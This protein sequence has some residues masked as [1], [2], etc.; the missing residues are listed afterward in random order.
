[1]SCCLSR[2]RDSGVG[3]EEVRV[4][5]KGIMLHKSRHSYV[6]IGLILIAF[7]CTAWHVHFI[8]GFQRPTA[9]H[10]FPWQHIDLL[11]IWMCGRMIFH[12]RNPYS[13]H[14]TAAIQ[15]KYY[16]LKSIP[17]N[18]RGMDRLGF[19]MG[20]A[21]PAPVALVFAWIMMLPWK[22]ARLAY[23]GLAV[24]LTIASVPVWLS[25]V[26]AKLNVKKVALYTAAVFASWPVLWGL[27]VENIALLVAVLAAVGCL[28]LQR[29]YQATAGVI[30][31][32]SWVKPQ[33]TVPLL[34]WLL[35]YSAVQRKWRF[36][37][38]F[39]GTLAVLLVATQYF[40]PKWFGLWLN[41]LHVYA[42]YNHLH[43][44]LNLVLPLYIEVPWALGV[45]Y[46]LWR[47]GHCGANSKVFGIAVGL[48]LA[49]SVALAP[50]GW[51][52]SDNYIVL[53]PACFALI[54]M[55]MADRVI[56]LLRRVVFVF[57]FFEYLLPVVSAA[58]EWSL[59]RNFFALPGVNVL[60]PFALSAALSI[61]LWKHLRGEVNLEED[62]PPEVVM[63][64]LPV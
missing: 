21:Y 1:M 16:G 41:V 62:R 54:E 25:V 35:F 34:L 40:L 61:A 39:G 10:S 13:S 46:I 58:L 15:L 24:L 60:L 3:G 52:F 31:A 55:R 6:L 11:P 42:R 27:R 19:A 47:A 14:A 29:G 43:L 33:L 64:E 32:L 63:A 56:V 7:L 26:K 51:P 38:A 53:L 18:A 57:L 8:E 4:I 30:L 12:G 28:L 20:F 37:T 48:A 45:A 9:D 59:Y 36:L 22:V 44:N 50:F 23:L 17:R 5:F 2:Y 49:T